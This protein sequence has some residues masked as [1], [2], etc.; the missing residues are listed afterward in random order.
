MAMVRAIFAGVVA[1]DLEKQRAWYETIF[2][3][4]PDAA[5]MDGLYEWHLDENAVQLVA[6]SK[7]REIQK[8]PDWGARGATSVTLIVEDAESSRKAAL[9]AGG[10]PVSEFANKGFRTVTVADPEGNLVTFLQRDA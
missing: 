10:S 3:R 4:V 2:E 5:P 1:K 7:V 8:L 6:L 9:S